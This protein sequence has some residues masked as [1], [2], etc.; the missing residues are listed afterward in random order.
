MVFGDDVDAP[1]GP[2]YRAGLLEPG[3]VHQAVGMIMAQFEVD[4]EDALARLRGHAAVID[5]PIIDVARAVIS[6]KL[7]FQ[8]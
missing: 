3:E 6:R 7:R 4:A 5:Q 1:W 8:R 2:Y